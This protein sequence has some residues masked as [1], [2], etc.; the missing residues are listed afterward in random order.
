M[1]QPLRV[2]SRKLA[3]KF[4]IPY[5]IQKA[6][7]PAALTLKLPRRL[8][9]IRTKTARHKTS[10]FPAAVGLIN[11]AQDPHLSLTFIPP[12]H[13]KDVDTPFRIWVSQALH[14]PCSHPTSMTTPTG[15][16]D[17]ICVRTKG[18]HP[19][20]SDEANTKVQEAAVHWL[21]TGGWLQEGVNSHQLRC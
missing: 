21:A 20:L 19:E 5:E 11:K 12:P 8:R 10:F 14:S 4:I 1:D 9:S 18:R 15:N 3:T 16:F 2:D 13:L 17:R 6:I 7:N